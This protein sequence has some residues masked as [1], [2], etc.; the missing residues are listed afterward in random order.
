MFYYIFNSDGMVLKPNRKPR[1]FTKLYR[2][3]T[4]GF[5]GL[6]TVYFPQFLNMNCER[7]KYDNEGWKQWRRC[8]HRIY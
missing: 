7:K 1:L 6:I 3:E 8:K 2:I 4:D 5:W